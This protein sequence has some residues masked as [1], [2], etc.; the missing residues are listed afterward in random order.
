EE[1]YKSVA[2]SFKLI[3]REHT[4]TDE[5]INASVKQILDALAQN[6]GAKLR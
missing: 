6:C 5:E 2:L 3:A 4:L 1:G